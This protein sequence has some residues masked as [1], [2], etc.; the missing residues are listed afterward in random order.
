MVENHREPL[1][2][3]FFKP[4][5]KSLAIAKQNPLEKS[6]LIFRPRTA[7]SADV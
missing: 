2:L 3:E 4:L 6:L 1:H 7:T 5:A